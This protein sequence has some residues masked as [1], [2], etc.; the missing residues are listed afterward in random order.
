MSNVKLSQRESS[1]PGDIET[2]NVS[3]GEKVDSLSSSDENIVDW[4][5]PTDP[6]N[7]RNWPGRKKALHIFLLGILTLNANLAATMFAP[8]AAQFAAEF[9]IADKTIVTFAVSIYLVGVAFGPVV[10]APL[11]EI[12]GRLIV[13]HVCNVVYAAFTLGCALST[14]APMFY[15]FR[16]IA[17]C[18]SSA[19]IAIG[20]GTI[21]DLVPPEKRGGAMGLFMLGA[22]LG[23]VLGP[24]AG[25]FLV[26]NVGWRWTFWL[27]LII[28]GS[29][30]L[31]AFAFMRETYAPILLIRKAARIRKE[32]GNAR[33][34]TKVVLSSSYTIM[35]KSISRPL[36]LLILTPIVTSLSLYVAYSFSLIFILFTTFPSVFEEQYGFSTAV[37]GLAY[38]GL[39][40]G[41]LVGLA[42]FTAV[43]NWQ[44]KHWNAN[45]GWTPERHLIPMIIFSPF[46][47]IGFF[48]Y[49]W[50]SAERT[51]WMVPITGTSFIAIGFLFTMLPTQLYLVDAFDSGAAA[52]AV[53]ANIILRVLCSAFITLAGPP[54]YDHL[55]LGWGNSLLGFLCIAFI[56]APVLI[57][58]NGAWLRKRF[59]PKL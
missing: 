23:P 3:Q 1:K 59:P 41:F 36:K 48:W 38:L 56:P 57:Y 20:G 28:G 40:V 7:P 43:N 25:G 39:G 26:A 50:S 9:R 5:S 21:A 8:G 22:L 30:T 6:E 54:L 47:A 4:D 32:T 18:S 2:G 55:G 53:A 42:A 46:T 24:V 14:N 52:S 37:S 44:R 17:G 34:H 11:S 27:I 58:R 16:F 12:H 31:F 35:F 13:Y 51:H 33:L 49:G 10:T 19:P 29:T 15:I 45:G